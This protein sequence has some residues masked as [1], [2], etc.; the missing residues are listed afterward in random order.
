[1]AAID[2]PVTLM[3]VLRLA[4]IAKPA[5]Q[6]SKTV[7]QAPNGRV[8]LV[9]SSKGVAP[10]R[11]AVRA[12]TQ[13]SGAAVFTGPVEVTLEFFFQRPK[14]HY[15]TGRNSHLLKD[16]AP[17][18]PCGAGR[19]DIDKLARAALDGLTAGGAWLDDAQAV[20]LTASKNYR[21][22]AGCDITVRALA[23]DYARSGARESA[24]TTVKEAI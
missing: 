9:E 18:Y 4:I 3:Q 11:E 17:H 23:R 7:R 12:E 5:P 8:N 1:M 19:N 24:E 20:T 16:D 14:S 6:G 10:F 22:L 21:P 15:R 2:T 13:R